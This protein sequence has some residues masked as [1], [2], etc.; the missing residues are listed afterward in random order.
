MRNV[1]VIS[2]IAAASFM[3]VAI[4][5][6]SEHYG[7]EEPED[8]FVDVHA[9]NTSGFKLIPKSIK[10]VSSEFYN[11]SKAPIIGILTMP[12]PA[13]NPMPGKAII[14]TCY[15]KWLE[16][17]G[18]IV[19][20]VPFDVP[21]EQ[22]ELFFKNINGL[23]ITGGRSV[24]MRENKSEP[25]YEYV[26]LT[27][28]TIPNNPQITSLL[29]DI[30]KAAI[31][32]NATENTTNEEPNKGKT[33]FLQDKPVDQQATEANPSP[34]T[35]NP[36][37]NS[38][39]L[40][41]DNN[42]TI[43]VGKNDT[44]ENVTSSNQPPTNSS[45]NTTNQTNS[46]KPVKY[47]KFLTKFA[48]AIHF[49][50]NKSME[51]TENGDHFPI[52]GV[53]LGLEGIVL[54]FEKDIQD[55]QY[56]RR[57]HLSFGEYLDGAGV[58]TEHARKS[59]MYSE[60]PSISL[61]KESI[62]F[63]H[64]QFCIDYDNTMRDLSHLITPLTYFYDESGQRYITSLEFKKYP[65]YGIQFHPEKI[66][67]EWR[68]EINR[69]KGAI[70]AA[71]NLAYAFVQDCKKSKHVFNE[72]LFTDLTA[73]HFETSDKSTIYN[74][75]VAI[76]S[77]YYRRFFEKYNNPNATNTT[78]KAGTANKTHHKHHH[79]NK[80][81]A[82]SPQNDKNRT[83][84]DGQKKVQKRTHHHPT[85]QTAAPAQ[86]QQRKHHRP[87]VNP[88][89][90]QNKTSL[91]VNKQQNQG[92][93]NSPPNQQNSTKIAKQI[94]KV[95]QGNTTNNTSTNTQNN[96]KR[97]HKKNKIRKEN[98]NNVT[99]GTAQ[100]PS[101]QANQTNVT[102][103]ANAT[104]T[105]E[106]KVNP[107]FLSKD[108][109]P[110]EP[111]QQANIKPDAKDIEKSVNPA[112]NDKANDGL[113]DNQVK[114]ASKAQTPTTQEAEVKVYVSDTIPVPLQNEVI[115]ENLSPIQENASPQEPINNP[116]MNTEASGST[117]AP[118]QVEIPASAQFNLEE[119]PESPS[120]DTAF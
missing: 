16:T 79:K 1:I 86:A 75:V 54:H 36:A 9:L 97:S 110:L 67:Y 28:I 69:T 63:Y 8:D 15:V 6:L 12:P 103:Q 37:D 30:G 4:F 66:S 76:K 111:S 104:P 2:L 113:L 109:K 7:F 120:A 117:D 100:S 60:F 112:V 93:Q 61:L 72:S 118:A 119:R 53:C 108:N 19:V 39:I 98:L 81:R 18:A 89:Q 99:N 101:S 17:S 48:Q 22:L 91:K 3:T 49:F 51:A 77:S 107:T 32:Q 94:K 115:Q 95:K 11:S 92:K 29:N 106:N 82:D 57:V 46:T 73:Y 27:N 56:L 50:V 40:T 26:D 35:A 42:V 90:L 34:T 114:E 85:N 13:I 24:L 70:M 38:T 43:V 87:K 102:E 20:P 74:S 47:K 41:F 59:R 58:I 45:D 10:A 71:F 31:M 14:P 33:R 5:F 64:H 44:T 23:M 65:F 96:L 21:N 25:I 62:F 78:D 52:F 88:N 80:T 116:A 55:L 83:H 105:Q 68:V 84:A